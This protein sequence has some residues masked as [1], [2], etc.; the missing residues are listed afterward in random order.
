M[1]KDNTSVSS[2]KTPDANPDGNTGELAELVTAWRLMCEAVSM[3]AVYE[4]NRAI[5]KYVHSTS[6]G[7]EAIQIATG[8][9]LR[10]WDYAAPYYRDESM[11]LAMGFTPY[12]LMLQLLAK[13]DDPFSAGRSYYSHP[14]NREANR[15]QM[16]HQ[17]SATGMQVIP[18]TGIAQ[19][20]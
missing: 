20:L 3:T 19:G 7:H 16:A 2:F 8:L 5:C 17:S 14:N 6:R 10:P 9:Q 13:A 11:L 15:P 12:E 18:A 1:F 4:A